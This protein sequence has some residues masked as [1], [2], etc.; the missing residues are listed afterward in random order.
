LMGDEP[1]PEETLKKIRED[2]NDQSK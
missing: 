1:I 2:F